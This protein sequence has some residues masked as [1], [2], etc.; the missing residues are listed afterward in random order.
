MI[1][2]LLTLLVLPVSPLRQGEADS[3]EW[4][5]ADLEEH[6]AEISAQIEELR[7]W[8]FEHPVDVAFSSGDEFRSYMDRMEAALLPDEDYTEASTLLAK[9]VGALPADVDVEALTERMLEGLIGGFY[10]P[11]TK[12]FYLADATPVSLGP[13][14]LAHELTHALDDQRYDL[15][16]GLKSRLDSTDRLLAYKALVEGSGINLQM[17]WQREFGGALDAVGMAAESERS[18]AALEGV[19]TPLWLPLVWTYMG[20]ADFL[21]R[22]DRMGLGQMSTAPAEDV[23]AAFEAPPVSTEQVLHPEKYWDPEQRDDPVPVAFDV[24]ELPE[25]WSARFEDTL[26]EVGL[27]LMTM[28]LE[29]RAPIESIAGLMQPVGNEYAAGW[30]GDRAILFEHADGELIVHLATVWDSARDAGEF[31]ARLRTLEDHLVQNAAEL[32][33]EGTRKRARLAIDYAGERGVRMTLRIGASASQAR[34]VLAAVRV[35]P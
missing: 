35:R 10:D 22:S 7:G 19:P 13:T 8:T 16:E 32:A 15:N 29:D 24:G 31:Y 27:F 5:Q 34:K 1:R 33:P 9:A 28:P 21:V 25:G 3:E 20:G 11:T 30:D 12:A 14:I 17:A 26:G 23:A 6:A 18:L 2:L 4:S